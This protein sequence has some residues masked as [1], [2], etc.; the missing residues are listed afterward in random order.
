M[1]KC[2]ALSGDL[3]KQHCTYFHLQLN[4][5]THTSIFVQCDVYLGNL[6][7]IKSFF[8]FGADM[9]RDKNI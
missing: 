3:I 7:L 2:I 1:N 9:S 5:L 8:S 4:A 6:N